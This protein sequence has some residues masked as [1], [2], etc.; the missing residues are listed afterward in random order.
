MNKSLKC[1]S[2]VWGSSIPLPKLSAPPWSP[3][4]EIWLT[5]IHFHRSWL[6][7]LKNYLINKT[8]TSV[9]LS[10]KHRAQPTAS[11]AIYWTAFKSIPV[12]ILTL[13]ILH[14]WWFIRFRELLGSRETTCM[15]K[16]RKQ[17]CEW[18]T[19]K[20]VY[21]SLFWNSKFKETLP[22]DGLFLALLL[23]W[24][25]WSTNLN[26]M[27]AVNLRLRSAKC[28]VQVCTTNRAHHCL[29]INEQS[30][31]PMCHDFRQAIL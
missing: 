25:K 21:T 28:C 23:I 9:L 2:M 5:V 11:I 30:T 17:N 12:D 18:C 26:D 22:H 15:N 13:T 10:L 24:L 7:V 3:C 20:N 27:N 4:N 1:R 8:S 16:F 19:F 14:Q 6:I 31:Y 29:S